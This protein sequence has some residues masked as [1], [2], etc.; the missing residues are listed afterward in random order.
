MSLLLFWLILSDTGCDECATNT[1]ECDVRA[2]CFNTPESYY[3][4][5]TSGYFGDGLQCTRMIIIL[6]L[7][8][9]FIVVNNIIFIAAYCGDGMCDPSLDENC[10]S[11]PQD[12]VKPCGKF[13]IFIIIDCY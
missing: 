10:V 12:C 6:F 2:T 11:C 1:D 5:C 8:S 3:C 9:L 4:N 7:F 13:I